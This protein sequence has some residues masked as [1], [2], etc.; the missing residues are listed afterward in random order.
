MRLHVD[1][2]GLVG[3]CTSCQ[4]MINFQLKQ[5]EHDYYEAEDIVNRWMDHQLNEC[6]PTVIDNASEIN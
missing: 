3:T 4:K 5:D 1:N 6:E 2:H